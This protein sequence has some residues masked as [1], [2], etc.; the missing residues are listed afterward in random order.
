MKPEQHSS[1][2]RESVKNVSFG[3]LNKPTFERAE[4]LKQRRVLFQVI[5]FFLSEEFDPVGDTAKSSGHR[6]T[7]PRR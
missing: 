6:T 2:F 4:W 3:G 1:L 5:D 7:K